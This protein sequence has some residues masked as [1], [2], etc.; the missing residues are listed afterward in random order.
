MTEPR[1]EARPPAT[2]V[3]QHGVGDDPRRVPEHVVDASPTH[4]ERR[5]WALPGLLL[6]LGVLLLVFGLLAY[7][8]NGRRSGL[9]FDDALLRW[10]HGHLHG[11]VLDHVMLGATDVGRTPG[12]AIITLVAVAACLRARRALDATFLVVAVLGAAV[13]NPLVKEAFRRAR[14]ALWT[15]I[16]P[17]HSYSFPS[18]H[19]SGSAAL[20]CALVLVTRQQRWGWIVAVLAPLG[21]FTIGVSRMYLG[22]HYP[23]DVLAGWTFGVAWALG[24][25]A[26]LERRQRLRTSR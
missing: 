19:A 6:A 10:I 13:L 2:E 22:V 3:A 12:L 14:P 23:S 24:V 15:S 4:A 17:E 25:H 21:A 8:A 11:T 16:A 20:A 5:P 1:D 9:P 26:L 18:G 7:G